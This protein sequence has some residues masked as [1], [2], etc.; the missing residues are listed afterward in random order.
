MHQQEIGGIGPLALFLR[1]PRGHGHGGHACRP[2]QGIDFPA[3]EPVHELAQQQSARGGQLKGQ[4]AEDDDEQRLGGQEPVVDCSC[5]HGG[6][7]ENGDDIH[8]GVLNG[9]GEPVGEAGLLEQ[10]AQHQAAQQRRHGGQQQDHKDRYHNGEEDLLLFGNGPEL[11]HFRLPFLFGG[12]QLHQRRLDQRDQRHIGIGGDGDGGQIVRRQL[13]GQ[14][15]GGGAV[16]PADDPDGG[17]HLRREAE[18]ADGQQE[19]GENAELGRSPQQQGFRVGQKGTEVRH[20]ADAQKD[21]G[22]I[23]AGFYADIQNI[24]QA[25]VVDDVRQADLS[26]NVG[27]PQLRVVHLRSGQVRKQHAEGDSNQQ[28]RLKLLDQ[29]Q[30]QQATGDDDHHDLAPVRSQ[31]IEPGGLPE[32]GNGLQYLFH[33]SF[34]R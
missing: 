30:I 25:A 12:Q 21:Q 15:D 5:A 17:R 33:G 34:L 27:V 18:H 31:H 3:G 10:I 24:Q 13:G 28:Q 20:G 7:Q 26:G 9:V 23:Q 29:T 6:G 32:P 16:R 11:F 19:R 4:Q 22:G 8:Q 14:P 1:D 2:D